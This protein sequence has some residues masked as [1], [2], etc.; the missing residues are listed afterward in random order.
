MNSENNNLNPRLL[1]GIIFFSLTDILLIVQI[2]LRNDFLLK[3]NTKCVIIIGSVSFALS[4]IA[5][6][7]VK[8]KY[9]K[10]YFLIFIFVFFLF[11]VL[12]LINFKLV[13]EEL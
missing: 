12:L 10:T 6:L 5:D 4:L 13:Y 7:F 8:K 9:E 1:P 2:I 11:F 3:Y